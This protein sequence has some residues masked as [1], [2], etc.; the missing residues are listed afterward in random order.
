MLN[1]E[2]QIFE[3]LKSCAAHLLHTLDHTPD[4]LVKVDNEFLPCATFGN[5]LVA[6]NN[7]PPNAVFLE[8]QGQRWG[9]WK[10][11]SRWQRV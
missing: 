4:G 8:H 5:G 6:P 1:S 7:R 2:K 10:N 11:K 9:L 3:Y